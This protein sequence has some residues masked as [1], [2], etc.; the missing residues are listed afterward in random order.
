MP[1]RLAPHPR[2][3]ASRE[4]LHRLRK[5]IA[6]PLLAPA[7]RTVAAQAKA[8]L[9]SARFDYDATTHNAHLIRARI[10]QGRVVT[11]LTQTLRSGQKR[12]RDAA[13]RHIYEMDRWTHWSWIA[14]RN[15]Q[16]HPNDI[17]DLSYGENSTTIAIAYDW[18]FDALTPAERKR[19]VDIA[20]RRALI[21]FLKRTEKKDRSWWFGKPDTNWNT[22]CAGGAGML[23]LSMYEEAPEARLALARAEESVRP[24]MKLLVETGGGWPEGIGY[25]NYG[26][27]YA[28]M[29]L[30]SHDRATGQKHPLLAQPATRATLF[31]PLDFCPRGVPTSFGDINRWSP[32]PFHYAAAA[33]MKCPELIAPL[34][35]ALGQAKTMA[36]I[37]PDAA[38]LLVLHPR[39]SRSG[40]S[41]RQKNVAKLYRGIDWALLADRWP[42]PNLYL[43]I[44][45]GTTEVP[46]SHRD[47]LS[48][49]LIADGVPFIKN[50]GC[51]EYLDTTFS[52]RRYELFETT[53]PSKNTILINGVGIAGKST[54][55]TELVR[56]GRLPGV[57]I[58]ATAA[59]GGSRDGGAA[60]FC[61]RLFLLLSPEAILIVD[62]IE[63]KF[64]ARMETRMHTFAR[65]RLRKDGADL[66][67]ERARLSATYACD[68]P[69]AFC[70]AAGAPTAPGQGATMLRWC[71]Q[72]RSHTA[73][74]FATLLVRGAGAAS[75]KLEAKKSGLAA[76]CRAKSK[77]LRVRLTNRLR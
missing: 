65:T 44:R 25:W 17:F 51:E 62:R 70:T 13:V 39:T 69:A 4:Q 28:F 47:L 75:V 49:H 64:P 48:F 24:F 7:A 72:D 37:W 52:A 54:V 41:A 71:T 27:R 8:Y 74:T 15:N 18:L 76:I 23:A 9:K 26:M 5:P 53:A 30:L 11:L 32:L 6:L 14:A 19:F 58:D 63:T 38:E 16:H 68:V 57:R 36:E 12:F 60:L 56:H 33:R 55:K 42:R 21:P 29:Y 34:D 77:T 59:M 61:G 35:E 67:R 50:I 31:F 10:M 22:V 3:Y 40:R 20:R 2:L 43:S 73:V 45:G 1:S 66:T 46:H